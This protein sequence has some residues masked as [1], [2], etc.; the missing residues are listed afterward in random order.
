MHDGGMQDNGQ[1]CVLF[2]C[3]CVLGI[4]L[5]GGRGMGTRLVCV[6]VCWCVCLIYG[7]GVQDVTSMSFTTCGMQDIVLC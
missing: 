3:V 7:H 2:V 4:H 5:A 6:F 1:C